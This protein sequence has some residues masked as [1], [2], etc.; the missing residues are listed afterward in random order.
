MA[1][2]DHLQQTLK[3]LPSRPGCYIMY[4]ASNRVIYVGKAVNL[5]ARVRSYFHS[6]SMDMGVSPKTARLVAD[7]DR[8]EF[9]VTDSENPEAVSRALTSDPT[10]PKRFGLALP[11]SIPIE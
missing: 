1:A 8:F 4:D 7:I 9:I 5:R 6:N 10:L 3:R 2:P 11:R